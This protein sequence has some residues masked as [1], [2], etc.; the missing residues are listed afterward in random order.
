M[1]MPGFFQCL[2][3]LTYGRSGAD[4]GNAEFQQIAL[5]VPFAMGVCLKVRLY[6]QLVSSDTQLLESVVL[7]LTDRGAVHRMCGMEGLRCRA[8]CPF[9]D[10]S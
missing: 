6:L 7:T 8:G 1:T 9:S 4:R 2:R 10:P 3:T 5:S